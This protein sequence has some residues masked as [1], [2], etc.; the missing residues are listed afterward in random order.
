MINAS[1]FV[2]QNGVLVAYNGSDSHMVIPEGVT[3][4]APNLLEGKSHVISVTIPPS[5]TEIGSSAFCGQWGW[6]SYPPPE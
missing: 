2:I 4:I 1:D 5:V 3:S 6:D